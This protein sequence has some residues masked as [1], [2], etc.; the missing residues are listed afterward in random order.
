MFTYFR[1]V[2][3]IQIYPDLF[4]PIP[5]WC[6]TAITST[7]FR[8]FQS[9]VKRGG[10]WIARISSCR[11]L[12]R[13]R[14]SLSQ[15][16]DSLTNHLHTTVGRQGPSLACEGLGKDE[17]EEEEDEATVCRLVAAR[18]MYC[19]PKRRAKRRTCGFFL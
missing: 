16:S 7:L 2:E 9:I 3:S 4:Y 12:K 6:F 13:K 14:L 8:S 5:H 18:S 1:L 10:R 15:S 19:H 11:P 17:G